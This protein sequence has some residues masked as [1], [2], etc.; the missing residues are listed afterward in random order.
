M[1]L[2]LSKLEAWARYDNTRMYWILSNMAF[3]AFCGIAEV[4]AKDLRLALERR[5]WR[6]ADDI[7]AMIRD[8]GF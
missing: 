2:E 5:G 4:D 8:R 7:D 3:L 1:K 6:Q